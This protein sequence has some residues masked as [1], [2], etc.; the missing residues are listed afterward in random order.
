M[1]IVNIVM[2]ISLLLIGC[3]GTGSSGS[4]EQRSSNDMP[5]WFLMPPTA[6]DAF[7]GVGQAKKQNPAL[8]KQTATARARTAISQSVNVK[9]SSMMKDFMQES[10]IG[11]TAQALEFSEAVTKQVTDNSLQGSIVK[12]AFAA[13][14][15]TIY[16]LVEY[17]LS[18]IKENALNAANREEALYNEFK[19]SQAF[20]ELEASKPE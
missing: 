4:T 11:E 14:D 5:Q 16:I 2:S 1:K 6:E 15:G 17:P 8:A 19:A 7:Y 9:V 18:S 3:A 12:E 10:G 20:E 13:K